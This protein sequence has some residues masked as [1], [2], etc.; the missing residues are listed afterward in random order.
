[1]LTVGNMYSVGSLYYPKQDQ[2]KNM[3]AGIIEAFHEYQ[4]TVPKPVRFLRK[5]DVIYHCF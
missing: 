4:K 1:M 3:D 2:P 5:F